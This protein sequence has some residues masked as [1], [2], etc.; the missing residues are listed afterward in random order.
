MALSDADQLLLARDALRAAES[1][2]YRQQ[3]ALESQPERKAQLEADAE[4]WTKEV[5]RLEK[6]V[7]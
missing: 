5:A 2:L 1:D 7:G 6:K 3:R 4:F